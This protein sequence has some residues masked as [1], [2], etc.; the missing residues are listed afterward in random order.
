MGP[1]QILVVLLKVH[2]YCLRIVRIFRIIS[3]IRIFR[4]IRIISNVLIKAIEDKKI[5]LIFRVR[6]WTSGFGLLGLLSY[7]VYS[8]IVF[9]ARACLMARQRYQ[10]FVSF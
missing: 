6:Y 8:D 5:C 7:Q 4:I 2:N 3:I 9:C 1:L 10:N